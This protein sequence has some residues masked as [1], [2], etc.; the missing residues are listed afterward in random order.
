MQIVFVIIFV[1]FI[2]VIYLI[3][4]EEVQPF[5]E[6]VYML[7]LDILYVWGNIADATREPGTNAA[8]S[9]SS[10]NSEGYRGEQLLS[11]IVVVM[12]DIKKGKLSL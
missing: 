9:V 2:I 3:L 8:P 4:I 11:Y 6:Y 10:V 5:L 12:L 1:V 7:C